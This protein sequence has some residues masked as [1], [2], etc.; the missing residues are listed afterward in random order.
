MVSSPLASLIHSLFVTIFS[1]SYY[2]N[3][4]FAASPGQVTAIPSWKVQS[5]SK[6]PIDVSKLSSLSFNTSSW[7]TIGSYGTLM[8]AL[9]SNNMYTDASIFYSTNLQQADT[10]QFQVPWLYRSTF[11]LLASTGSHFQLKTHG[12]T[13]RADIYLNGQQVAKKEVQAG[14]YS[15]LTYDVSSVVKQENVLLVKVY[16]TDY[17]RDFALGF[18]DWNPYPPDN[19]TGIW[20]DVEIQHTGPVSLSLPRV[21]TALDGQVTLKLDV[22]SWEEND[23]QGEVICKIIDD[24]GKE[25]GY[26]RAEFRLQSKGQ[27]TVGLSLKVKEPE[28]WWPKQW[29]AQPL[30]T[31]S[32]VASTGAGISD[33]TKAVK[34]GIR[35]VTSKLN[36]H[37]DTVFSI[38]GKPFQVLGAGYTSDIFLR[39]D[40]RKLR[41]QFEYMLD[42]GLNTVRL[43]GKQEH[44]ALYTL[45]D[46]L[47]LMVMAG[48]ECCDK[49]E[50]WSYNDE[51][52]GVTWTSPDYVIANNSM[53]H[54]AEMMQH[55][56]SMLAFLVG[57]D[58]WPDDK[59]TKI[60][61][62]TLKAFDW[63][64]PI[65]A[66]A[67]QRGFPDALGNGG[68][69]MDGPYDWV[70][71]N[72]WYDEQNR[73]GAAFG[74]GSELGAGV[75]TP[76]L[77]S[78]KK[79][80]SSSDQEDL[81]KAPNKG[82][83]HM[84]TNVSSFYTREIYNT[85]LWRRYGAPT[86]LSNYLLKAQMADYEA[87]RAQFEAY[88]AR[89]NDKR[90]ATGLI[91]WML[92]NAWP[93]LHWN[94]FD[95]Y[96]RPAGSFF[97][98]KTASRVEHVA[99]DYEKKEVYL[100]N[101]SLDKTGAR[102][103]DIELI[104]LDGTVIHKSTVSINTSPN[105]SKLL[106]TTLAAAMANMKNVSLLRL[107]L[108]SS[109][110][111][112]SRNVYWL[113]S[114]I[115]VLDWENSTWY[116]TPLTAYA[117][118]TTM[119]TMSPATVS[120]TM[121]KGIVVLENKA[122]VPAVFVR[123]ELVDAVGNDI[124][125]VTWED[126]Y[127]SLWPGEKMELA[128]RFEGTHPGAKVQYEGR[129]VKPGSVAVAAKGRY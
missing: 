33:I 9:I 69:K 129:N 31:T 49:W 85:G 52:S 95:Y 27:Q 32:C 82:L 56:P 45:A 61:V 41:T 126:N 58:F 81:W 84:S 57:S 7:Y 124:L 106:S 30:Y 21:I 98:V 15:G 66:S 89:W 87:T 63:N 79:F 28:I 19:G 1:L 53:R 121:G 123:L 17:N 101:R 128:V 104:T 114:S 107:I 16:P 62:D 23:V 3:A 39:F 118:F 44:P 96:L 20:R 74:F 5:S 13:S 113:S 91:Y 42:M 14:A 11:T 88:A 73:L 125:P 29:G 4:S 59:A 116:H 36:A 77:G 120:V 67:S 12:I 71:P 102:R 76:E 37:N 92:N 103:V 83:Y 2:T 111:V 43:E 47:G 35:I 72:Y 48:W 38:N 51:G 65:I 127:V 80:L 110:G 60:Y 24:K 100:I 34:F 97:G 54:E 86:S 55:H 10:S 70:S 112:L 105:E 50:G 6:I 119:S 108:S 94:L 40:E 109:T 64:V 26:S 22:K 93:S 25:L 78:L 18:V 122:E 8:S 115:D 46:E 99:Y 68:M 117:N 75:G 90:P